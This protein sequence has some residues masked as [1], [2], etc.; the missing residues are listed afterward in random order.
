MPELSARQAINALD[1]V[2]LL[3]LWLEWEALRQGS[4]PC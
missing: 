4:G 3:G 1:L 2:Q